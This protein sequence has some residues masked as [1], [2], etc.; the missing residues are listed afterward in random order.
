MYSPNI[1]LCEPWQS[2]YL[3]LV[4]FFLP[5]ENYVPHC[6][7]YLGLAARNLRATFSTQLQQIYQH[8][9]FLYLHL[10]YIYIYLIFIC[11]YLHFYISM[12]LYI[13]I[14]IWFY[15]TCIFK[16]RHPKIIFG[17]KWGMPQKYIVPHRTLV[18]FWALILP[19]PY[20]KASP[21]CF[22]HAY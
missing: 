4:F 1:W 13:T 18:S 3:P 16:I 12:D 10:P 6:I 7:S 8:R 11:I 5:D 19:I 21:K 22:S 17:S 20:I 14:Y 9:F 15:C 2:Q